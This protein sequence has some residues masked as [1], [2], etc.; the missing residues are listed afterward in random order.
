MRDA[1]G[2]TVVIVIIVV[3]IVIA[4]AYM[5]FN[6]NYTKAFRMKNKVISY[7]E[8]YKGECRNNSKCVQKIRDYARS[9]GYDPAN[10]V[11]SNGFTRADNLYCEKK[12]PLTTRA[13]SDVYDKEI[14]E[15]YYYKIETKIDIR[16][17]IVDNVMGIRVFRI[18]GDTKV[19]EI[20]Y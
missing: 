1:M 19:F 10:L 5:A 18:T 2:G 11:C 15:G 8:E 3:F 20:K 6:V 12:V 7:Y 9:I 17:P 16:I 14:R 4:S 13:S